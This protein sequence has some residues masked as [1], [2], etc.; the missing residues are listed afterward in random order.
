[1]ETGIKKREDGGFLS[2]Q[3]V[4]KRFN[5]RE[6][7]LVIDFGCGSG[8]WATVMAKIVGAGGLILAID[9]YEE[10]LRILK[11]KATKAGLGNIKYFKAPYSSKNIPVP[12]KA[13][14]ILISNVLSLIETDKEL[15]SSAKANAK[16]GTK[17]V[18]IDWKKESKMGP[19]SGSGA[20]IEDIILNAEKNGFRFKKLLPCGAHH[21]G[22]YFEFEGTK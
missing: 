22:L 6:G 14:L 8:Y 10:N 4:I 3:D 17:L 15:I 11:D 9:P 21:F 2:P 19:K 7:D 18:V 5:L 16:K 20:N 1:M 13:D 12:E